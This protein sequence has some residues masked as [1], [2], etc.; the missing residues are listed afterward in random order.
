MPNTDHCHISLTTFHRTSTSLGGSMLNIRILT[1]I[2]GLYLFAFRWLG[3][4]PL[5]FAMAQH[6]G[7]PRMTVFGPYAKE[8]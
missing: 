2:P 8:L 3:E 6:S 5:D 1:A 4:Q 7:T